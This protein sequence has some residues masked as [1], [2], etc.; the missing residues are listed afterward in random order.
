MSCYLQLFN[1]TCHSTLSSRVPATRLM[2][3][4][5]Q[6]YTD[7]TFGLTFLS[8]TVDWHDNMDCE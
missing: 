1:R 8:V 7:I 2:V 4:V 5:T 3:E 6:R